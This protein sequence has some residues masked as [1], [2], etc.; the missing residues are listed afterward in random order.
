MTIRRLIPVAKAT[1]SKVRRTTGRCRSMAGKTSSAVA[2]S[3]ADFAPE[4]NAQWN[5][6]QAQ[7]KN[8][9]EDKKDQDADIRMRRS[10]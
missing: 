2:H 1:H 9:G 5:Q 7:Y 3:R 6:Q 10:R 8:G 4:P